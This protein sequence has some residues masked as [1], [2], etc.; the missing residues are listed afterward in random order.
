[1]EGSYQLGH[2]SCLRSL[3][4]LTKGVI[5]NNLKIKIKEAVKRFIEWCKTEEGQEKLLKNGCL[6][7]SIV[8]WFG[9]VHWYIAI[10]LAVLSFVA[11]FV[12][13]GRF[14]LN[15]RVIAGLIISGLLIFTILL[16]FICLYVYSSFLRIGS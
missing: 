12:Y 15:R 10:P 1:M 2:I 6:F 5:L 16:W 7:L 3:W 14:E 13:A 8:S 4:A 9:I 11:G